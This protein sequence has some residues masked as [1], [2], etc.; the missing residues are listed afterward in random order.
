MY[1]DALYMSA[2][3]THAYQGGTEASGY[4]VSYIPRGNAL[5][6]ECWGYLPPDVAAAFAKEAEA[7]CRA[8][9][10]PF[11]AGLTATELK[12]QGEEGREALRAV[13]KCMCLSGVSSVTV[14]VT[15]ILT[16]MQLT[17]LANESGISNVIRFM[18]G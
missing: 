14:S 12:P 1:P 3:D 13:M 16:R 17:R 7:A 15:N 9:M 11:E 8:L 2:D 6:L 5:H 10:R 18:S 4:R